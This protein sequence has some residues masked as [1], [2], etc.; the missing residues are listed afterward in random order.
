[1]SVSIHLFQTLRIF[2][3]FFTHSVEYRPVTLL[4]GG[5]E[6]EIVYLLDWL[7]LQFRL[8]DSEW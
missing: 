7:A 5:Y 1:M 4:T 8:S 2:S 6:M 3:N